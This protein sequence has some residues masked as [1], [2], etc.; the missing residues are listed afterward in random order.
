MYGKPAM[1]CKSKMKAYMVKEP[2]NLK[3]LF[4]NHVCKIGLK[5]QKRNDVK[6]DENGRR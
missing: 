1:T 5:R 4:L 6:T 3:Q 2:S